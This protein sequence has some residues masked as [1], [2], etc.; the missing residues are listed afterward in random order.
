LS[1]SL[2]ASE[3]VNYSRPS[4][5]VSFESFFSLKETVAEFYYQVQTTMGQGV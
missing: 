3:E 1:F 5:D 2:D 4:I